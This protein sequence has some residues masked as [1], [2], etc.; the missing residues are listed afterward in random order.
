M[1][2]FGLLLWIERRFAGRLRDGDMVLFY[3]I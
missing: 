3:A 1:G 2:G